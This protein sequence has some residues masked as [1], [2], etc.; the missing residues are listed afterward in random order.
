MNILGGV[1]TGCG[2]KWKNKEQTTTLS[3]KRTLLGEQKGTWQE[4]LEGARWGWVLKDSWDCEFHWADNG[5]LPISY[6]LDI[7]QLLS[8]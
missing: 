6:S 5:R 8:A 2:I 4:H 7:I 1:I 3:E